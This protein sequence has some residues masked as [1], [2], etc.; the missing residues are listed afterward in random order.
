M[1][2]AQLIVLARRAARKA[3]EAELRDSGKRL[4][5]YTIRDIW[6]MAQP[7]VLEYALRIALSQR[8]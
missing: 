1:T 4:H 6:R 2:H 3:V 5:D 8:G 7:R